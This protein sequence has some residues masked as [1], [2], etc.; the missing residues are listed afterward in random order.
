MRIKIRNFLIF[1]NNWFLSFLNSNE[2]NPKP[3]FMT[4]NLFK[5]F[6]VMLISVCGVV[7]GLHAQAPVI[8]SFT[9]ISAKP[10]DVVTITGTGFNTTPANNIVFFGATRATVTAATGTSVTATVPSGATY[11]PITLLNTGTSLAAYS[12]SNFTPTYSPTKTTITTTDFATK[13]DFSTGSSP[14]SVAIGDLD[15]DGKPDLVV[16]NSGSNTVSVYLNTATSGSIN[17]SS[18]APKVDFVTG[19]GNGLGPTSVIIGDLDGDGKPDLAIANFSGNA[20]TILRNTASSGSIGTGSFAARVDFIV[21]SPYSL[22]IGDLDGDGKPDLAVASYSSNT[23]SILRNT[24]IS[25]S[26]DASSFAAK[27][28]FTTGTGPINVAIGDLDGDGKPDLAVA[29]NTSGSVS[30]LRNT[31]TIGSIGVSSFAAKQDFT[32]GTQTYFLTIGDL[33]GDGKPD[34]AVANQSSGTISLFR[35]TST[36]GSFGAGSFASKVDFT[37]TGSVSVAIADLD[38]DGKPDLVATSNSNTLSVFRNIATNGSIGT[39]SFAAKVDFATG[40]APTS[41]AIGDVD[42]DGRPDLVAANNGSFTVSVLRNTSNNADLSAL[43]ISTGVL[44]PTFDAA[45][46]AYTSNVG[47]ATTSVTVT[48]TQADI[49]A[50]IQV[51][52]NGGTYATVLSG[53]ASSALPLNVGANTVDVTV[54]AQNGLTVKT[55]TITITRAQV[56]VITSFTPISAKPGDVVTMTGTGFNTTPANNIV[57]FGATRATVTAATGTSVT[58]TVPSG[59]TYAPITLLNTGTSLAAYSLSNF[60]PT[61]SPSKTTIT[62]TDFAAKVDFTTGSIPYLVAIGDL[63]GDG[64]PD[65]AVVN[66][67]TNSVSIYRNTASSGSIGSGS[68]AAKVDFTMGNGP[69]SVAIGDLDGDGKPDLVV[70]STNS[71]TVSILRNTSTNGS[72]NSSSFAAKVDFATGS[73]PT[74]VTIG[75]LDGDGKPDLAVTNIFPNSVSVLRNTSTAG[76]IGTGSFAASVDFTTGNSPI[77]V[78]IGD[79]D[80]DG[81]PDLAVTNF[82]SNTVSVLRNTAT[83]GSIDPSSFAAKVDYTTG[84]NPYLVAI[85][86]LDGDGKPDLAVANGN[87]NTVSILRNTANNGSIGASSFAAKVDFATGTSPTSVAI[88]DVDGDG[89][90]DL[91]VTNF[92]SNTVSV[93]RNIATSGSIHPSSFATKVDYTT[94]VTPLLVAIGDLDGDGKPDLAV[95][96]N[97]VNT[98]SILRNTDIVVLPVTIIDVKAFIKDKGVQVEWKTANEQNLAVYEVEKSSDGINFKKVGTVNPTG[99]T[100]Y[101]WFDA[102]PNEGNN[103]YRLKLLDFNGS[104]KYTKVVLEKIYKDKNQFIITGNPIKNKTINLKLENV[105]KG[106]YYVIVYNEIGQQIANKTVVHNGGSDLQTINL[107]NAQKGTYQVIIEGNSFKENKTIIVE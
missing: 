98:V 53:S 24:S 84:V 26:I 80:G 16:A 28:G 29:N 8:T 90:P 39:S 33:D 34:L 79:L 51:R 47:N 94:G 48:P 72:I 76:S 46:I 102:N 74:S 71:N 22:A 70:A 10:G 88:G 42:G 55:Y 60:T 9:P 50:T 75:D 106:T 100:N 27:V 73:G 87:S 49:N 6:L 81:K 44:S 36:S 104:F 85:G 82:N 56:P 14:N 18:F 15:G 59:A 92:N 64:R 66:S 25:G 91:A 96:N 93:L 83:V 78:A 41:V 1:F 67:V 65:L 12:L 43:T 105:D 86:D 101:S 35:N 37:C 62:S 4:N 31:A 97:N 7:N 61:Y 30:I 77:S 57:F 17:T 32:S 69:R 45:T 19:L 23:V 54:T 2:Y 13:V 68:F 89:K 99:T 11:A 21:S 3:C 20:V 38:G 52:V 107:A 40:T 58:A 103:Y 95:V 63:D 5:F